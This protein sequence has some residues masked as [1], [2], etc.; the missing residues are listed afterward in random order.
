MTQGE[1][2]AADG[3]RQLVRVRAVRVAILRRPVQAAEAEL[4]LVDDPVVTGR[5]D[6]PVETTRELLVRYDD[7]SGPA[8]L[9]RFGFPRPDTEDV[10]NVTV[11]VDRGMQPLISPAP[12]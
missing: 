4:A 6:V 11:R 7:R 3:N 10:V 12:E 9:R 5:R 1:R 2:R 8:L